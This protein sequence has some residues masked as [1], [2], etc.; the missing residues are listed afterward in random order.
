MPVIVRRQARN[1]SSDDYFTSDEIEFLDGLGT[2]CTDAY[3]LVH[4]KP[5]KDVLLKKYWSTMVKRFKWGLIDKKEVE[6]YIK[7]AL[8]HT[9][10]IK[11]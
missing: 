6:D 2:Y 8:G 11:T 7:G 5:T 10:D 9:D 4:G 1:F 3:Y